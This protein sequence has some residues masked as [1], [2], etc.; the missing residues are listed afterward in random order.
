MDQPKFFTVEPYQ[1]SLEPTFATAAMRECAICGAFVAG[2]GGGGTRTLCL[3]CVD[4]FDS[5][6]IRKFV[7]K[8]AMRAWRLEKGQFNEIG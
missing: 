4:D 6:M 3:P 7:D 8:A 1:P 2:S 5:G